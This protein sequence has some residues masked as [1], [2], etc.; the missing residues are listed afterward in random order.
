[1]TRATLPRRETIVEDRG[2]PIANE[3]ILPDGDLVLLPAWRS[4]EDLLHL[5]ILP[6]EAAIAERPLRRIL[7]A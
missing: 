4:R 1:M 2:F 7:W 5:E 6:A 3:A